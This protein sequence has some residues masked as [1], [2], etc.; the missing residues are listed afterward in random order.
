[1]EYSA[2]SEVLDADYEAAG[3]C[4]EDLYVHAFN[5]VCSSALTCLHRALAALA[6]S[7]QSK[8]RSRGMNKDWLRSSAYR[9]SLP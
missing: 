7:S 5:P 2:V 4:S 9:F 6:P 1:M 8:C 3:T